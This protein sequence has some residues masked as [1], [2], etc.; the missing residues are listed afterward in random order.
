MGA[1]HAH[2]PCHCYCASQ[3]RRDLGSGTRNVLDSFPSLK[4]TCGPAFRGSFGLLSRIIR[5]FTTS[6]CR[7]GSKEKQGRKRKG[8][9]ERAKG[10]ERREGWKGTSLFAQIV[11]FTAPVFLGIVVWRLYGASN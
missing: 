6:H 3:R 2:L 4:N 11:I 9:N 10:S 1:P 7:G 5:V 8:E